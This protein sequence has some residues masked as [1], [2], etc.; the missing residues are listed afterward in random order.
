MT[1]Q[2]YGQ[3][4]YDRKDIFAESQLTEW[5]YGRNTITRKDKRQKIK[6]TKDKRPTRTRSSGYLSETTFDRKLHLG[7]QTSERQKHG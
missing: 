2:T 1:E 4:T 6:S 7:K 3:K 5:T